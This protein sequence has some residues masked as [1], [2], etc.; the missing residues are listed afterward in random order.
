MLNTLFHGPYDA[1]LMVD[2]NHKP[3]KILEGKFR[4]KKSVYSFEEPPDCKMQENIVHYL[5]GI[6]CL[7]SAEDDACMTLI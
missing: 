2:V 1:C 7:F 4:G 3:S 5:T 6:K